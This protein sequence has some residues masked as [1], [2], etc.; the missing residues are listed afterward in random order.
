MPL[1]LNSSATR[2]AE[3]E[4]SSLA[5]GSSACAGSCKSTSSSLIM[6]NSRVWAR[7]IRRP[8]TALSLLLEAVGGHCASPRTQR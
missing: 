2:C 4:T 5:V 3:P 8:A 7:G 6:R 1:L